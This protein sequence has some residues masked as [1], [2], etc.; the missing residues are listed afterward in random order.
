LAPV[1][2]TDVSV[3]YPQKKGVLRGVR[4]DVLPGE[5]MGLVG[6]SGSGKSTFALAIPRLLGHTG[7]RVTG[8]IELLGR[9]LGGAP[10]RELRDV[11]G[12]LVSLVPQSPLSALNPALRL[13]SHLREAWKAHSRDPWTDQRERIAKLFDAAGLPAE[14][15]FLRRRPGEISVGQAQ[16]V[17]IVMALLHAP[18]LIIADE[19]TSALDVVTA[20][21]VLDLLDRMGREHGSSIL[22]I[23]H[24]LAAV[25]ERC[26][27]AAILKDG[28]IAE[29]G[30][31]EEIVRSARRAPGGRPRG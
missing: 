29:C 6:E 27:R 30:P 11:R 17:L 10:E 8:R 23:S 22:F 24:D 4:L 13:E 31:V 12:R 16:R 18:P 3:D 15:S 21:E 28:I 5:M 14:E 20:G 26:G 2:S 19:P 9:E 7:A 25:A 1:L